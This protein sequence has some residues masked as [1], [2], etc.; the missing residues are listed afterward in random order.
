MHFY[1]TRLTGFLARHCKAL[2]LR[3]EGISDVALRGDDRLLAT[4]GWDGRMRL[5]NY[6]KAAPLAILKVPAPFPQLSIKH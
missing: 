2:E 5:Y 3:K 1:T 4:A 6:R